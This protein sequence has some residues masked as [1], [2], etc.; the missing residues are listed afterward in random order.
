MT[1]AMQE[2]DFTV[3]DAISHAKTSRDVETIVAQCE[4]EFLAEHPLDGEAL[5]EFKS[6]NDLLV[7]KYGT[8]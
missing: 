3:R 4:R 5:Q 8:R 6:K 1:D 7:A 2:F